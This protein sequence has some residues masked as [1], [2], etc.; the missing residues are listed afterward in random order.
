[1]KYNL[2]IREEFFGAT[3]NNIEIGKREYI[4]KEELYNIMENGIFF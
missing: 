1:M 2:N 4:T 3:L